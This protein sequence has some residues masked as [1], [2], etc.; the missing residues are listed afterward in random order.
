MTPEASLPRLLEGFFTER[1]MHQRQASPHTIASYRDTFSLLL[2][3]SRSGPIRRFPPCHYGIGCAPG[4][5]LLGSPR[6]GAR[7]YFRT[8]NTRL[9]ALHAF[10]ANAALYEPGVSA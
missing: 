5:C 8:R 3:S 10:F 1:L 2:V 9:A 7:Q 6:T 4:R